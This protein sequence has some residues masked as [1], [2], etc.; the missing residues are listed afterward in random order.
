MLSKI[1]LETARELAEE[2]ERRRLSV[3]PLLETPLDGLVEAGLPVEEGELPTTIEAT[4][5]SLDVNTV[6]VDSTSAVNHD[7]QMNAT[8]NGIVS[9]LDR[10]LDLARNTINPLATKYEEMIIAEMASIVPETPTITEVDYGEFYDHPL[11]KDIFNGW[12]Y[13][14]LDKLNGLSG[15]QFND[16]NN[17][18]IGALTTGSQFIDDKLKSILDTRGEEW[19]RNVAN[20]YF[21]E[22]AEVNVLTPS[23]DEAFQEQADENLVTHMLARYFYNKHEPLNDMSQ[24][25][26]DIHLLKILGRTATNANGLLKYKDTLERDGIVVPDIANESNHILVYGPTYRDYLSKGGNNV[27]LMGYSRTKGKVLNID[28]LIE[29]SASLESIYDKEVDQTVRQLRSDRLRIVKRAAYTRLPEII[30]EIPDMV[31]AAIPELNN[32][33]R[34]TARQLLLERGSKFIDT[35]SVIDLDNVYQYA[36][37]VITLGLLPE[38]ELHALYSNM[39]KYL[40]PSDDGPALTPAQAAYYAVLEEV[41]QYFLSQTSLSSR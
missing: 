18:H 5:E 19:Y 32:D 23:L 10:R 15:I 33:P 25:D 40:Q 30:K 29:Q 11:V 37:N 3:T 7:T 24:S 14:D 1:A 34:L 9:L 16:E 39:T 20:K 4:V 31:L 36:L 22:A 6:I 27:A 41:V 8:V 28:K 2:L 21:T 12:G 35:P 17:Y 38:L 26:Y 13:K